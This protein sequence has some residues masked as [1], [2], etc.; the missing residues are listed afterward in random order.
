MKKYHKMRYTFGPGGIPNE[1][2]DSKPGH[3]PPSKL[4]ALAQLSGTRGD[5]YRV[6]RVRGY[7]EEEDVGALAHLGR[8][9]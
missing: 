2:I 5:V 4:G 3:P 8:Y 9:C 7:G 1:F 6:Y